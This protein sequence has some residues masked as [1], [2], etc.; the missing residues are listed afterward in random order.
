MSG[1]LLRLRAGVAIVE[2]GLPEGA[3]KPARAPVPPPDLAVVNAGQGDS[4]SK[5]VPNVAWPTTPAITAWERG[6]LPALASWLE[7]PGPAVVLLGSDDPGQLVPHLDQLR[8]IAIEFP[9]AT[10]GRGLSSARILRETYGWQGELRA[11]GDVLVDQLAHMARC[12][13]SSFALRGDQS[14]EVGRAALNRPV[15]VYR[16]SVANAAPVTAERAVS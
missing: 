10:D 11:V 9:R 7:A 1:V 12:G 16:F 5:I 15:P 4:R 14:A 3:F 6:P 2:T 13:F 8:L